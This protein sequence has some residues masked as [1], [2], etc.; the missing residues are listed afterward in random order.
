METRSKVITTRLRRRRGNLS[1]ASCPSRIILE[2]VTSKWGTL[3]MLYLLEGTQRFSQLARNIEGVSE[4]M[5]AQSL[6][7]LEGDGFVQRTVHPTVPPMVDY[8]L[9]PMGNKC[10]ARLKDFTD[11]VEDHVTD[12]MQ[13]QAD[14]NV[15]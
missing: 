13:F 14:Q 2:H 3:V 12:V 5:L 11:W 15:A 4:K 10:A 8:S 1:D 6:K 9:T 7:A